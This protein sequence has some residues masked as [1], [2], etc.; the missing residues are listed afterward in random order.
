MIFMPGSSETNRRPNSR[1]C[2][3][4]SGP[5]V[6]RS[7]VDVLRFAIYHSP[8]FEIDPGSARLAPK[9]IDSPTESG[10]AFFKAGSATNQ[11]IAAAEVMLIGGHNGTKQMS[12]IACRLGRFHL[13]PS[14]G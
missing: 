7:N 11:Y 10:L 2:L 8:V 5:C 12:T 13:A 9:T 3:R 6:S 14:A 4:F 1:R